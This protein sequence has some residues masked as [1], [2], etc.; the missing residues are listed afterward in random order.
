MSHKGRLLQERVGVMDLTLMQR[1][2]DA[3]L[4]HIRSEDSGRDLGDSRE[5][6]K[7]Q[8]VVAS[9]DAGRVDKATTQSNWCHVEIMGPTHQMWQ[10]RE[11]EE[12]AGG[13]T[14]SW[15]EDCWVETVKNSFSEA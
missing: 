14:S 3:E 12:V 11:Q 15:L 10:Q 6:G 4:K 8:T 2:A 9:G 1:Q 5:N 7:G 13:T